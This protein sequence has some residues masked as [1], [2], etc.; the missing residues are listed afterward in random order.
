MR[1]RENQRGGDVE[2]L[3]GLR[4]HS[5]REV[6][7]LSVLISHKCHTLQWALGNLSIV[8]HGVLT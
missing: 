3:Q 1:E 8:Q 5:S 2:R 6:N 4:G 7:L